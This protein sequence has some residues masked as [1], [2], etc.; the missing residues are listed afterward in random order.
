MSFILLFIC[1][2]SAQIT[3]PTDMSVGEQ[4]TYVISNPPGIIIEKCWQVIGGHKISSSGNEFVVEWDVSGNGIVFY[5]E[6]SSIPSNYNLPV[7]VINY[8]W[9]LSSDKTKIYVDQLSVGI[10]TKRPNEKLHVNI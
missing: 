1:N 5:S 2:L 10:G 7:T 4:G 9:E 8:D 3:G 6:N